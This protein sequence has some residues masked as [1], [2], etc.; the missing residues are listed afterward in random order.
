MTIHTTHPFAVPE[1]ARD[2]ARQFRGR[3][4]SPVTLW[5]SGQGPGRSGLT[6]SSLIVGLG[7]QP[8]V[9]GLLDPDSDL[10]LA[11]PETLTI[12]MLTPEDRR[13]AD[14]FAGVAPA[15]GGSFAQADFVDSPWGPVLD[16]RRSWLGAR[17]LDTRSVGWSV[18]WVAQIEQVTLADTAPLVHERGRYRGLVDG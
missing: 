1:D 7:E 5:L 14:A 8:V 12:S 13:L 15:P 11:E 6:V 9:I 16:D 2:A 3:L 4:V 18:E 10:A 17:V